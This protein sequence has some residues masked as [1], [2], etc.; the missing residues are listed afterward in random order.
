MEKEQICP[1]DDF[2]AFQMLRAHNFSKGTGGP[3]YEKILSDNVNFLST[4]V[5]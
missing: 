3:I 2:L 5:M 4:N 1:T